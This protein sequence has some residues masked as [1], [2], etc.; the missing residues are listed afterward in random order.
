MFKNLACY[1]TKHVACQVF[2]QALTQKQGNIYKFHIKYCI[3][4]VEFIDYNSHHA[5]EPILTKGN[6]Y[7]W[8]PRFS[9]WWWVVGVAHSFKDAKI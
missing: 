6:S 7:N 4:R 2:E 1:M 5:H 3:K 9:A 8:Q